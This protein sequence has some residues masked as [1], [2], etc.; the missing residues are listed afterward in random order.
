MTKTANACRLVHFEAQANGLL[1]VWADGRDRVFPYLWMRD[2]CPS[3]ITANGQRLVDTGEIPADIAPSK[4]RLVGKRAVEIVWQPDRHVSRYDVDWLRGYADGSNGIRRTARLWDARTM[5]SKLPRASFRA[6]SQE[7]AALENWLQAVCDFGFAILHHV[8]TTPG[9]IEDVVRL[10]GYVRETNY[11]RVFDV[12]AT[13][14]PTNL[15]YTTVP[16]GV[17]TDNPYRDPV[18]TLQLLHCLASD[19]TGGDSVL[20]DGFQVA[21]AFRRQYPPQFS[22]LTLVP[23]E[24]RFRDEGA[25]LSAFAPVI[26]VRGTEEVAAIRFNSRA[27][28]PFHFGPD[29]LLPYYAA[30]RAFSDML[31]SPEYQISFRM[32]PGDLFIVDNERVLHGR[33]GFSNAGHRHLQGCYADRDGLVSRLKVLR[34]EIAPFKETSHAH[35]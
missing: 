5:R 21:E 27:V 22:L 2:N 30:Y 31:N 19:A 25:D 11:G 10:F 32:K 13:P 28:A 24:F 8:P 34:R 15:A 35:H 9:T 7:P 23:I 26:T 1:L 6:I 33:T 14:N 12:R 20:V 29:L 4:V 18:P 17:H 16:L 3:F